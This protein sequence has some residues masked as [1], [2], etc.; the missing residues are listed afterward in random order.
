MFRAEKRGLS[1]VFQ[2][3]AIWPHMTVFENVAYGLARA[4]HRRGGD[5]GEGRTT[6]STWC[7]CASFAERRASQLSG[8][9][10]Q[11]VALARAFVFSA[12]GTAV[13]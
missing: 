2:S 8:G 11:R 9:Q 13:R 5:R 10:Q 4:A 1:M 3:Y 7:R 6:R 12:F